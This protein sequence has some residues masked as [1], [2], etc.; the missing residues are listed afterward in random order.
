[1]KKHSDTSRVNQIRRHLKRKYG[2]AVCSLHFADT[3]QLLVATI[4]SAQCTDVRVNMVTPLLFK[5]FPSVRSFAEAPI[6][7]I[8]TAIKSTGFYRNKAKNIQGASLAIL[9]QFDGQVPK[10]MTELL[11]L[12]GVGR[13]TANVVLG[14]GFGVSVG[15]VVDTHVFRISRRLGI[16]AGNTPEKVERELMNRFPQSDW[17]FLSHAFILHGRSCCRARKP[18]CDQCGL[19]NFCVSADE[20]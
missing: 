19:R 1:M 14:N 11:T 9:E 6:A 10:T 3:F 4:L 16:A 15:F 5:R 17:T 20:S 18:L 7:E 13:K 2:D 12:P 8:E